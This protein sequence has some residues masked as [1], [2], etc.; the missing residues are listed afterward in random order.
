MP[1]NWKSRAVSATDV[2][3]VVRS[4]TNLFVHGACATPATLLD[5]L[6]ERRD[7]EG[8]RLYHLHTA[9]P[10]PF[11]MPGRE[12]EFRSVSLFTGAPLRQPI[13]EQRADFVPIF[14]SDIPGLFLNGAVPLDVALL[15]VS[16]PDA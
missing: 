16:P 7:L 1:I 3:S 2:V 8:V 5:A 9:G 14:L 6:C 4:G 13:A 12:R 15:Q 11:A 10:A